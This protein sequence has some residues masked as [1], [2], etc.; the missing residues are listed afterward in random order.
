MLLSEL[1]RGVPAAVVEAG[2]DFDVRRLTY[3]SRGVRPGDLFVAV[4]GLRADGHDYAAG[5][6][7]RGAAVALER[8][9]RLP[10]G[11]PWLR[12]DDT[13][14]GLGELAAELH[15]RPARR[16]LMVGVTGT[17]G[18][19]T[20]THMAAHVLESAGVRTGYLSTVA[21]RASTEVSDNTSGQSTMESPEVQAALA[22][23]ASAGMAAAVVETTSHALLQGRVSACDFD[24]VAVTNVGHD[25]LDYH[26]TWDAYLRA[27]A[28]IIE[29]CGTGAAKGLPKTAVLNHDDASYER[30]RAYPIGRRFDYAVEGAAEVAAQQVVAEPG[31]SR[32]LLQHGGERRPVRLALPAR[33]NVSNALC[34]AS[35]GLS[36]GLSLEQVAA[37]LSSFPGVRGRL[38]RLDLGQAFAVYIDFAHS[39][40]SLASVLGALRQLT[41]GRLLVVFGANGRGDHDPPGMGRAAAESADWFVITTDD[42]V[43]EDPSELVRRVESGVV[44]RVR[45]QDYEVEPDRRRA[46]RRAIEVAC[47]GDVVL[48]A[49]KGHERTMMLAGGP[50]PWDE[51]A[52]AEAALRDLGLNVDSKQP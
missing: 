33:F 49:G 20:V 42:P 23:M 18:K 12:L 22:G 10:E 26:G 3:D 4:A 29:L 32:F 44:G 43:E 36:L 21:H 7:A 45:G 16:L 46:I 5:A 37:G 1:A 11:T 17:D 14:W 24:V 50:E 41:A 2:G 25:H 51:R 48:L 8:P 9:V 38:E 47:P 31:G 27:K 34:A 6:A 35:I 40:S 19:T 15:G 13:R 30:L 52:E 39:S 28:L